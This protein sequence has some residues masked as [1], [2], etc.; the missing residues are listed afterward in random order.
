[1]CVVCISFLFEVAVSQIVIY[2]THDAHLSHVYIGMQT[3]HLF[4]LYVAWI[5]A[6]LVVWSY[7]QTLQCHR[8]STRLCFFYVPIKLVSIEAVTQKPQLGK[9]WVTKPHHALLLLIFR[10]NFLCWTTC[11]GRSGVNPQ[12]LGQV[13][14]GAGALSLE[15]QFPG[16]QKQLCNGP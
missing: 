13:C 16:W 14:Q 1:M 12:D 15:S 8:V 11:A 6:H 4:F 2:E 7:V 10:V 3:S 9:L 5:V